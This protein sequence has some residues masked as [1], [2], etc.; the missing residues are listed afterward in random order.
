MIAKAEVRRQLALYEQK[1]KE[2]IKSVDEE[3]KRMN[4]ACSTSEMQAIWNKSVECAKL[5][6]K[7]QTLYAVWMDIIDLR[8]SEMFEE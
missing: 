1:L 5:H 2:E 3:L 7:F 6:T 4:S 8:C